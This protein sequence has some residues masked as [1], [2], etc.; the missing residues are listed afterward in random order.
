MHFDRVNAVSRTRNSVQEGICSAVAEMRVHHR[1]L[2]Y[3]FESV[4][5]SSLYEQRQQ[6]TVSERASPC[7]EE[8]AAEL[9][10]LARLLAEWLDDPGGLSFPW[11][12]LPGDA[13]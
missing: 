7:F 5:Q 1:K 10:M 13:R 9:M 3:T 12:R 2:V 4:V 8:F 11:L 6:H